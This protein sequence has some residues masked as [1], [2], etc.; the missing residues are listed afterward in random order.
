MVGEEVEEGSSAVK[1]DVC[2]SPDAPSPW[3]YQGKNVTPPSSLR[4]WVRS[5]HTRDAAGHAEMKEGKPVA[6]QP[7]AYLS[8]ALRSCSKPAS[9]HR[10]YPVTTPTPANFAR[11]LLSLPAVQRSMT[12]PIRYT[13]TH[14][15]RHTA[16]HLF[17]CPASRKHYTLVRHDITTVGNII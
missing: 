12:G 6:L 10:S 1:T 16:L 13:T 11:S 5:R 7:Y 3:I 2:A 15:P 17:Y 8:A 14:A 4:E 9:L